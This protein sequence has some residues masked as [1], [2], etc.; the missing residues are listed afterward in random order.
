MAA[1]A[2]AQ[3]ESRLSSIAG[4]RAAG[5]ARQGTESLVAAVKILSDLTAQELALG[6]GMV[7]ERVTLRPAPG[8]AERAGRAVTGL[9]DAEKILLDLAAEESALVTDGVK[10]GLRLRPSVG[11]VADIVPRGM[12]SLAEVHKR[13]LDTAAEETNAFVESYTEG[14]PLAPGERL[15]KLARARLECFIETQKSILD[16]IAE[17]VT[18]ATHSGKDTT[19][20]SGRDR[21]HVVIQTARD[22]VDKLIDAQKQ[23]MHLAISQ[24]EPPKGRE[25]AKPAP[26]TSFAELT[27]KSVHNI[28][29]AQK[30]LLDLAIKPIKEPAPAATEGRKAPRRPRR[31]K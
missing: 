6:I 11:A 23:L 22:S 30:S 8:L 10:E 3:V 15:T 31:K 1:A 13:F 16:R 9:I 18:L 27:E 29:T 24:L 5:W 17:Q 26:R 2:A 14:K 25:R 7:R 20:V 19:K 12:E 4:P 21:T 28:T